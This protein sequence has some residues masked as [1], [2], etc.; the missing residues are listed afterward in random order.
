MSNPL[1]D[2]EATDDTDP[3]ATGRRWRR[4]A[5]ARPGEILEAALDLFVEKGFSATRMEE[6]AQRA[7]VTKGTLYLYF[8]SKEALFRSVVTETLVPVLEEGER[9]V[10]EFQGP[11]SELLELAVRRW[12]DVLNASRL[13]C[14]PKLVTSES[15]NFP[16][17]ARFY[18]GTVIHRGR[19][20]MEAVLQ[21]GI[22]RGEFRPVDVPHAVRAILSGMMSAAIYKHSLLVYDSEPFDFDIYFRTHIDVILHGITRAHPKDASD[23]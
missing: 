13:S 17:V 9:L 10:G 22:D 11:T 20:L 15:A 19:H 4:R 21:R 23:A 6:I 12:W 3:E 5:D 18:M 14:L 2:Q 8:P 1:N 7:G 16:E